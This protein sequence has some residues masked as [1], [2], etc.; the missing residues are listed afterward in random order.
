M[1]IKG[2]IN[3]L[4]LPPFICLLNHFFLLR[5]LSWPFLYIKDLDLT[6]IH[7]SI[8]HGLDVQP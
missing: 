4:A 5:L 3:L 8:S 7:E 2:L 6:L 1:T